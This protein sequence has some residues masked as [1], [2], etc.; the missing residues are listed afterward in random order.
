MYAKTSKWEKALK[1]ARD[2]LPESE[3]VILYVK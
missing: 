3:I 2:N 1:V